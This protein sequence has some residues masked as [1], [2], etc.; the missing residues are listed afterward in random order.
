MMSKSNKL[1]TY[2]LLDY[3]AKTVGIGRSGRCLLLYIIDRLAEA[4]ARGKSVITFRKSDLRGA[5]EVADIKDQALYD[6]LCALRRDK[7]IPGLSIRKSE[8]SNTY[9]AKIID[10]K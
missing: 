4:Q 1:N 6:G 9:K 5:Y 10:I 3:M 8:L 2:A 7:H